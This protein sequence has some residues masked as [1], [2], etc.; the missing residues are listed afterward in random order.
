M[1]H[2]PLRNGD[3]RI[4]LVGH[5]IP[6]IK[7]GTYNTLLCLVQS[8]KFCQNGIIVVGHASYLGLDGREWRVFNKVFVC[9]QVFACRRLLAQLNL[10]GKRTA[11]LYT[12][13]PDFT[14]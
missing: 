11:L 1:K 12:S 5:S 7:N 3:L 6:G 10:Q 13:N 4:R 9:I 8:R 2:N 14:Y